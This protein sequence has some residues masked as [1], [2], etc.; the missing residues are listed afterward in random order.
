MKRNPNED[1]ILIQ[2]FMA[3]P[4]AIALIV[5]E[6]GSLKSEF[7]PKIVVITPYIF[8]FT[9][10][11]ICLVVQ[12][13]KEEGE[14]GYE[15]TDVSDKFCNKTENMLFIHT[16]NSIKTPSVNVCS[17]CSSIHWIKTGAV[18]HHYLTVGMKRSRQ[19]NIWK[20]TRF[21]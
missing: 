21:S 12:T 11:K 14:F 7:R 20:R 17:F 2:S 15:I 8:G 1:M 3:F 4:G 9:S 6:G 18:R 16:K 13:M 10:L 19:S 5:N